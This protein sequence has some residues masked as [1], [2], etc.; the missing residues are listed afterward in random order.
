MNRLVVS[1]LPWINLYTWTRLTYIHTPHL[2]PSLYNPYT[3][4]YAAP[5]TPLLTRSSRPSKLPLSRSAPSTPEFIIRH[6]ARTDRALETPHIAA[7]ETIHDRPFTHSEHTAPGLGPNDPPIAL[8]IFTPNKATVTG[9]QQRPCILY[10]HGGGL[11]FLHR[12]VGL[13]QPLDWAV[14]TGAVL[15]SIEY[16]RAPEH[17]QPAASEDCFAALRWVQ[18]SA[19]ALS[20]DA[21]RILVAGQSAGSGLA[22]GLALRARDAGLETPVHAQ[23]L[24]CPM[25]DDSCESVSC[26]QFDGG[27]EPWDRTKNAAAWGIALGRPAGAGAGVVSAYWA[28][29]RTETHVGLPP[30]YIEAGSAEFCRDEAVEYA[31]RLWAAG[32]SADLHVW[33]GGFHGFDE[34]AP[35]SWLGRRAIA[36]KLEWVRR[37]LME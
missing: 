6:H 34:M 19:D 30:A 14:A 15:V 12:L 27:V 33:A 24:P 37:V 22:A 13:S 8:S 25:L 17:P 31:S 7:S 20:I 23:M 28:P 29:A 10:A 36:A 18:T 1:P 26:V 35:D 16:R 2:I 3:L 4:H 5:S 21:A 9:N 11:I 32:V